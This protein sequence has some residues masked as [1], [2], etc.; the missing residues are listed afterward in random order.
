M[1]KKAEKEPFQLII[2]STNIHKIREI[3]SILAQLVP[4][5]SYDLL[6]LLDFPEYIPPFE[7]GKTF[8]E[9]AILKATKAA[10]ALNNWVLAE[11]SGL[12]VPA[13]NGEPG[14][15]SARYSGLNSSDVDNR[16]KLLEKMKN[17]KEGQRAAYFQCTVAIAAPDGLKKVATG[18]CEGHI[19]EKAIGGGGFGYDPLFVKHGYRKTFAELPD[20]LKNQISH[21]RKALEKIFMHTEGTS[22]IG[23]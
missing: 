2:A 3:K 19:V 5:S 16:Q 10:L 6:S 22:K 14:I 11:D 4:D 21:R 12:V 20:E 17:L 8:E 23:I 7:D 1:L 9:N 13:L 18:I 15:Y